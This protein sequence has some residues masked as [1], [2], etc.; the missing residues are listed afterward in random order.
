MNK[1][2]ISI[3]LCCMLLFTCG[4]SKPSI[5][6]DEQKK[7]VVNDNNDPLM[8]LLLSALVIYSIKIL[9]AR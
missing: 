7:E 9:F 8:N 4:S 5:G 3:M 6:K 2:I 1:K